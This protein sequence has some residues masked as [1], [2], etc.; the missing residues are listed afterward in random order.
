M[1]TE[2]AFPVEPW[3]IRE[4]NLNL[5]LLAQSE[6]LFTLSNGHIGLRGNLDEGEPH[7][8]PGTYLNSF[9][10]VRPLPYA[11]A[12]FGYPEAGQTVVDVSNGKLF[13]LMVD[14]ELFDVRYGQLIDHERI[15]DLRAG[16]LIRQAHWRS[17]AGKQVKMSSTRLVSLAQRSVAAIEYVVEA[18]DEFVRITVQSELVTNEDQPETSSDPRVAAVLERPLEAVDHEKTENRAVLM[19]RTRASGLMMSAGMDHEIEV[20]GR[21]EVD[22]EVRPDLARTTVICG[23]RPGQKL[24]IVK[25]LAYGWSSQRSRPALRDQAAG[26]LNG[27][28][29]SGWQGLLDAQRQR[30]DDFW[31]S[32]DVEVEGDPVI[33]QAVR[34]GLFHLLQASARAERRGIASKGLTGTGYD[35]HIFWDT[36]GYVL[37]VLTYTAPHAAADALRWRASTIDM[38]KERA[39]ELGLEGAAFPW[40]TIRGQE[41]SGYWPAGTAAFHIN[42]DIAMAFER[43]RVVTGDH[44]LEEDCG[45][46]V[47]IETARLWRSLGHHDRH[48]VWHLDGVTGP[49]EYTA[50]VR[51]NVFTNLMAAHN[52]RVAAE[53]CARHPE[54]AHAMGVTTEEMASWR[55]AANAANIPYDDE[56]GVH[57]QCEGFTTFAEWDFEKNNAYPLLLHEPYVRLYPAQVVKQADL[58]LAMQWQSHAFTPEQKARNVDYYERRTVRDSSLSA[59]TQAVMCA[60]VGHLELAHDYA[61]EAALIDLRD[62]HHNS[63]DGLHM[64]SLAGAWTALVAGFGGLRDDEGILSLNPQ[65]PD[66]F[67]RLRFR[68]IWQG[69]RL[70]VSATH[71]DVTYTLRDGPDG[72]GLTIRHAGE[73]LKL[74]TQQP[75][76]VAVQE[77]EP[78]LPPPP[79]PPGRE[80][81]HRRTSLASTRFPV[82][83]PS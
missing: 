7:G 19:H 62:L 42:A 65:L 27:A 59:C 37:P 6:S 45:L 5:N 82:S 22:T 60:E 69:F 3:Q 76:T 36:E 77:R 49:D 1:I 9:Y 8:L 78:V 57:K 61:Y 83:Q 17:P 4:T 15:L 21:V 79:Q 50:I 18:L 67:G 53:A 47:L 46:E 80:P 34:F 40:R 55:D 64:A 72:E 54:K 32:A 35:G 12:G 26:A 10:E 30:L 66:E 73:E 14:D 58:V 25:Y 48:G 20:P 28:R 52:L 68:L 16:A 2:D 33:Q 39:A 81:T 41:C 63:R 74:S 75:T 38:A 24:R 56:L 71:N 11:E 44:S 31:E 51:D 23:L 29:Y 43:Y 13:R 70:T